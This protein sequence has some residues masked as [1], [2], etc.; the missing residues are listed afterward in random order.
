MTPDLST[1]SASQ[2]EAVIA[3]LGGD[4]ARTYSE[5]AEVAGISLGS[6][7]TYLSWTRKNHPKVY[8]KL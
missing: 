6:L 8:K 3:L 2:R 4:V 5:A 1:L 7:Y